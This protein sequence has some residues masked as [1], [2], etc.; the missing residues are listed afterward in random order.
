M[1]ADLRLVRQDLVPDLFPGIAHVRPIAE[2]YLVENNPKCKEICL[3]GMIH[4]ADDF[5]S[6]IAW[7]STG[8]LGVVLLLL[9]G[10]SEISDPEVPAF[11]E[12]QVLRLEVAMDDAFGVGVFKSKHDATCYELCIIVYIL[13]CSSL[14]ES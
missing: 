4:P 11:F 1:L 7:R 5:R 6:H 13:V 14:K 8:L 3:E 12:D 9:A 10:Y 2:H